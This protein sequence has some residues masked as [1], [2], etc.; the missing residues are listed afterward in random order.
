MSRNLRDV[1]V[2]CPPMLLQFDRFIDL[3]AEK[4]IRLHR[5]Q[6]TQ[7][8]SED[9]LIDLLPAYDGWIIGDDPATRRV[10]DGGAGRAAPGGGEMGDR[11]RQRRFRGLQAIWGSL[12]PTRRRCS[13]PKWRMW[14]PPM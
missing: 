1:I 12:S 2:T 8:L 3:A 7:I 4:G 14:A 5:A 9:E 6:T 11:G 13:A 10:F